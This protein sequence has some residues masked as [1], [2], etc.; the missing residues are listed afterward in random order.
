MQVDIPKRIL[1]K[2]VLVSRYEPGSKP[3]SW[4]SR[5]AGLEKIIT[6]DGETL[7]LACS[8]GQG[9]PESGWELLLTD[10]AGEHEGAPTYS[11]TLYGIKPP[12]DNL[13]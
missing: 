3:L 12:T 4:D 11:W 6:T 2:E 13:S 8:G 10:I 1:V 9:S 5:K 7:Q